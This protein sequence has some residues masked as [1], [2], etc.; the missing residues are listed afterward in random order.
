MGLEGVSSVDVHTLRESIQKL[1]EKL[2]DDQAIYLSRYIAKGRQSI[3][4]ENVL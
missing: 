2:T 3:L 4:I 1:N